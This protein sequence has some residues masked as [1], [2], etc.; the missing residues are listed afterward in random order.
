MNDAEMQTVSFYSQHPISIE[1]ILEKLRAS[2]RDNNS[3]RPDELWAH[4][5]DHFGGT[6]ATDQLAQDAGIG[7]GTRVVDLCAGL[8]GTVRYLAYRYGASVTGIELTPV[9]VTGAQKLIAL[10][11]LQDSSRVIHGDIMDVP[12]ADNSADVV[13]SQEALCHVPELRRA[14]SEALR[15]LRT[16][17][18]LA[19]TDWIA[20]RPLNSEDA[21]LMWDGMAIQPLQSLA[22]YS[23]LVG[24][25][26][27][28]V[29]LVKDLTEDWAPILRDRLI[30]YQKLREDARQK[31]TPMGH[32]AFHGSYIRFVELVQN[33]HL[34]GIRIVAV[35]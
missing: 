35:K 12:L 2:G 5:Q 25:A 8:G 29:R 19:F 31:G 3:V 22:S 32:D 16:G 34:G 26:G 27:F 7:R 4:D 6:S 13:I 20:N 1:L 18:R 14:M 15:I 30:M 33:G 28:Q 24:G 23:E 17:G 11:G 9:R 10:V 21:K